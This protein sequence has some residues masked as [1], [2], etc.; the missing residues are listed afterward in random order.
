MD[1]KNRGLLEFKSRRKEFFLVDEVQT[2][3][4]LADTLAV[5][6]V[7][8]R[9]QA[10]LRERVKELACFYGIS[11]IIKDPSLSE[12]SSAAEHLN[13]DPES[14]EIQY[15]KDQGKD[16]RS[17]GRILVEKK[18]PKARTMKLICDEIR[19]IRQTTE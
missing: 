16:D 19:R 10:A 4:R 8:R 9:A 7:D 12:I 3:E 13:L 15:P 18:Y 5:A 6:I 11:Q 14:A 2:Y 17:P 1:K